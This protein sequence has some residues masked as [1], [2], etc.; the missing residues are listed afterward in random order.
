MKKTFLTLASLLI[1]GLTTNVAL[2]QRGPAASP[3]AKVE[4]K[5]GNTTMQISYSRPSLDGRDANKLVNGLNKGGTW[6]T[7]ADRNTLISFDKDVTIGGQ[8]LKAGNYSLW[9]I[10]GKSEWTIVI[11]GHT[12]KWGTSYDNSKDVLRFSAKATESKDAVETFRIDLTDFD[13]NSKDK[14]NLELAWG[15]ISV[16]FPIVVKN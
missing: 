5:I 9:T 4:Q 8:A 14:A 11:S 3:L 12:D 13:K 10:P 15:N 2:A 6:R 1:L 16:K 7:G